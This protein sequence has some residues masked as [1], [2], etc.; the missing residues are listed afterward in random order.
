[1][2]GMKIRMA[3][4]SEYDQNTLHTHV[5]I[6]FCHFDTNLDIAGKRESLLRNCLYLID[7]SSSLWKH[8]LINNWC[9]RAQFTMDGTNSR[10]VVLNTIR[11]QTEQAM[12]SKPVSSISPWPLYQLL[13]QV[14]AVTLLSNE[15]FQC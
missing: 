15:L 11:K 4:G 9:G 13:P 1:M 10:L 12:A 7:L 5:L 6:C 3:I 8:F 14:S 2:S